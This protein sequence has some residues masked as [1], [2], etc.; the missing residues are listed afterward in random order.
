MSTARELLTYAEN[1]LEGSLLTRAIEEP[2]GAEP[3]KMASFLI[4]V[5]DSPDRH[6]S[7]TPLLCTCPS[8]LWAVGCC[9]REKSFGWKPQLSSFCQRWSPPPSLPGQVVRHWQEAE[10]PKAQSLLDHLHFWLQRETRPPVAEEVSGHMPPLLDAMVIISLYP[11]TY[12]LPHRSYV[13]KHITHPNERV[14]TT[15]TSC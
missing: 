11:F 5:P 6:G 4:T 12:R 7:I 8:W 9:H 1:F 15:K 10:H 14:G 13:V 3:L 2:L